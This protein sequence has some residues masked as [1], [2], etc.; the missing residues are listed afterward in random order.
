MNVLVLSTMVPFVHGG[1]EELRDNLV[2]NL[3]L[4]GVHAEAMCLPFAWEPA[5]QII[6]EMLI[7]RSLRIGN[8]DRVISL[9]F[10]AYLVEHDNKVVW[11]LHQ[12]RQAYD[13]LD[14]GQSNIPADARGEILLRTI[15]Q[16]DVAA[17]GGARHLYTNSPVTSGRLRHYNN[18]HGTVLCPP[19]NNPELFPGGESQGYVLA[20]GRINATKRQHLLLEAMACLHK[21]RLR[22][23]I[24]GPPD[25]PADGARL[26]ELVAR[27]GLQ[28]RV[29]LDL[30]FL[31]RTELAAM[32]NGAAAVAYLP[33]NED[34]PGYVTVE[35]F[36]AGKPVLTVSDAGGVLEI[37][38]DGL[39][40]WVCAPAPAALAETLL[41][42]GRNATRCRR[43]GAAA[44]EMLI[45]RRV[46]WADTIETLL[47]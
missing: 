7:A 9:K 43:M 1:A 6:E 42:A 22:L 15:H 29:T 21:N 28:D 40:G 39:T 10:P 2:A 19:V 11:L 37:V 26:R 27:H 14:A 44:R 23:V 31:P 41:R 4:R 45:K 20:A 32:V 16:A 30:R 13:M 35:A 33:F 24:A 25:T 18:L 47:S 46:T 17:L 34:S 3:R 5:E 8:V 36:Q 12:Y 38:V